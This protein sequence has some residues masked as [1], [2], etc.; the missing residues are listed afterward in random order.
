MSPLAP[1]DT[2]EGEGELQEGWG[3]PGGISQDSFT[4][5]G[6]R[7]DGASGHIIV[8]IITRH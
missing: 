5:D 7:P 8:P 2:A 6:G 1:P 4:Q 3:A